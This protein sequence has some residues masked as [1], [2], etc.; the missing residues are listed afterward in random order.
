[1]YGAYIVYSEVRIGDNCTIEEYSIVSLCTLGNDVVLAA[2]V[3]I[4]SGS[5]HHDIDDLT[6]TFMKTKSNTKRV[7]I[8]N[9]I[10][11]GTHAV[12]MEDINSETA[13]AAG[14]VVNK[15]FESFSLIGG[16]PA[17][18]IRKRGRKND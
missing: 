4:M 18:C 2:R 9:N 11:I 14:A 8:G 1:M 15:K 5:K 13:V 7:I 3:S 17:K 12:I 10:W 16:I 6:T